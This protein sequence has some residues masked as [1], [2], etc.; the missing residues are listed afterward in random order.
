MVNDG[1]IGHLKRVMEL[2][3]EALNILDAAEDS[4]P[5]I[6]VSEAI[7]SISNRLSLT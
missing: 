4:L 6:K 5:A 2:L 1:G 3:Q 7:D